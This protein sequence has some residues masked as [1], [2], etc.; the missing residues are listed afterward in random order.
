MENEEN[1]K[2]ELLEVSCVEVKSEIDYV[3]IDNIAEWLTQPWT[4]KG[5]NEI[6]NDDY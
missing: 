2:T 6:T 3:P 1:E 4:T 5:A